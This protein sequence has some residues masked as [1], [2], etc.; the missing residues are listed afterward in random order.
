MFV[1]ATVVSASVLLISALWQVK[2]ATIQAPL[3]TS[4]NPLITLEGYGTIHG[5]SDG[6]VETYLGLPYAE[7]PWVVQS[8]LLSKLSYHM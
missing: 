3:S 7:P 4:G 2:G 5:A 6:L 1:L 8:Y